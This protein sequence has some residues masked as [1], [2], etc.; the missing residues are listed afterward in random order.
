MTVPFLD[1]KAAY[2][3]LHQ[4]LETA[5]LRVSRSGCYI[6]G[7]EVE[8][9]EADFAT[10]TE[11]KFCV[12]VGNGL[13]ALV[14]SLRA[15][16]IGPG[17]EVI[18]PSHTFIATWLA[19]SAVG[20]VPVP[21][22]PVSGSYVLDAAS[23]ETH[24][25]SRTKA[26]LP[27]HLYGIPADMEA[28]CQLAEKYSLL[29][30]EDAAQAHGA[31]VRDKKIGSHGDVVAWSFYPGKNLGALGDG[32]AITTNNAEIA[33]RVRKLGNYGSTVKYYN[34]ELG[35]NSRLD[36]IQAAALSVKL[37]YLDDWNSR[38][39]DIA[40]MY[41]QALANL[42]IQLPKV[43]EWAGAVWHL[44]VIATPQ[45]DVLQTNLTAAGI[46]TLIHY[47]VP[48]HLQKAYQHLALN[49]GNLPIAERYANELL[50]LPIGPQLT[51]QD[52]EIVVDTL[53]FHMK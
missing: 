23:A 44:F 6:G 32:G 27:V 38:R 50:S 12:G 11:A 26:I 2:T 35:I 17:D 22:E 16:D 39:K 34:E 4:E 5:I 29:V 19:V 14:L 53:T 40:K 51:N 15:L 52:V 36:P 13:D 31:S 49:Q 21:V 42:P 10:Y 30:I 28:I 9:F 37:K 25:T 43:P 33:E 24:I 8:M 48:P 45:R 46:N 1:L 3:E 41:N 47:P 20:A 18:V 7:Q